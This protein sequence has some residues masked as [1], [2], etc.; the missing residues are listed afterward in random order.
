MRLKK[1]YEKNDKGNLVFRNNLGVILILT[2]MAGKVVFCSNQGEVIVNYHKPPA[3]FEAVVIGVEFQSL[4]QNDKVKLT[5][6]FVDMG[7]KQGWI[8][9]TE[10]HFNIRDA[11]TNKIISFLILSTPGRY[12]LHCE[13]KLEDDPSGTSARKHILDNHN[14]VATE[15]A[16][17]HSGYKC[18]NFYLVKLEK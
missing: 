18:D 13:E 12:C 7:V 17:D 6:K 4:P 8:V 10:K 14:G 1:I 11:A 16:N 15:D 9:K 2:H 3:D 5:P